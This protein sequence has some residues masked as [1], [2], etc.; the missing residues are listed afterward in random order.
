M[1]TIDINCAI[2]QPLEDAINH[3]F[4]PVLTG[5]AS[6]APGVKKLLALPTLF[7]GLNIVNLVEIAEKINRGPLKLS[8]Y[9]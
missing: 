4:I 8:P 9:H 2:F 1:R 6:T 7:G 5:Q 3:Q